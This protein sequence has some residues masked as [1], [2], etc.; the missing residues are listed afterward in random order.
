MDRYSKNSHGRR[1]ISLAG[2]LNEAEPGTDPFC[3][4]GRAGAHEPKDFIIAVGDSIL[5]AE[6]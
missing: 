5:N 3:E 6:A 2:I 1:K 4:A